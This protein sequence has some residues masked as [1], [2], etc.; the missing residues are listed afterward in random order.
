MQSVVV[1]L[2]GESIEGRILVNLHFFLL[3]KSFGLVLLVVV[4][5]GVAS[6]TSKHSLL[7]LAQ[8]VLP[9]NAKV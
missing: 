8:S 9:K 7:A 2:S 3:L 4:V 1:L 6:T 5:G